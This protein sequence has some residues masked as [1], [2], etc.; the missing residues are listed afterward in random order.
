[1]FYHY[2]LDDDSDS[3]ITSTIVNADDLSVI[4]MRTYL[5]IQ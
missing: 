1:M 4:N 2:N 5:V 3:I